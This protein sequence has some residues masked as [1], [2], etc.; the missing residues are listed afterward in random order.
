MKPYRDNVGVVVFN[1]L[2]K[3]L[4]GERIQYPGV[5][6][7]PQGGLD[8]GE[9]PETGARRELEEETSLRMEAPPA[10]EIEEWLT[11]EFPEDIPAHL[12]KYRGQRQKW[13]FFFWDGDPSTLRLDLHDREFLS[14][15]WADLD[16][17]ADEIVAFK[18]PV[19]NVIRDKGKETIRR[20]QESR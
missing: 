9:D 3:V 4:V 5:F 8:A 18:K 14:V 11:Y 7:F 12:K 1:S 20:W 17:I 19:Y 2:G 16:R 6:Q 13:F 10:G 15:K